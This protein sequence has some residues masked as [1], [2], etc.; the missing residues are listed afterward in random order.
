M[1][2]CKPLRKNFLGVIFGV[3]PA[4][5]SMLGLPPAEGRAPHAREE[6][7]T[8]SPCIPIKP[9]ASRLTSGGNEGPRH[10]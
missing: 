3:S 10:S 7:L 5:P 8:S 4:G 9:P 6:G 2:D 1:R